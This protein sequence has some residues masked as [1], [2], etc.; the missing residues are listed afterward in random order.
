MNVCILVLMLFSLEWICWKYTKV[1][2][3]QEQYLECTDEEEN[4]RIIKG[5]PKVVSIR[6]I[7]ALQ[8]ET[9][10]RKDCQLY[11]SHVLDII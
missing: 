6:Q 7:S 10:F 1:N 3:I 11:V 4:P 5:I 9:L 8:L 2:L